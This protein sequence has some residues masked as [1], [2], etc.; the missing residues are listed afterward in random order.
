MAPELPRVVSA[1]LVVKACFPTLTGR[2]RPA[3]S[4]LGLVLTDC[5]MPEMN[6]SEATEVRPMPLPCGA[7]RGGGS[8]A[9]WGVRAGIARARRVIMFHFSPATPSQ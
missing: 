3:G 2:L 4:G 5:R 8:G 9:G 7:I 6:G 1:S